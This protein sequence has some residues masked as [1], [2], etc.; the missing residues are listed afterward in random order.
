[1]KA[2]V[3]KSNNPEKDVYTAKTLE[4]CEAPWKEFDYAPKTTVGAVYDDKGLYVY[5]RTFEYPFVATYTE[6][7]SPVHNDSCL[8]MFLTANTV[9]PEYM[10]L[11]FNPNGALHIGFRRERKNKLPIECSPDIFNIKTE[12]FDDGWSVKFFVPF[13]FLEKQFA[14]GVKTEWKVNF[15]KCG[16]ENVPTMHFVSW[17]HIETEKPDFHQKQFFGTLIFKGEE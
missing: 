16:E 7:A 4:I 11:E 6:F 2:Y 17:T 15:Y 8:E 10:N 3:C 9:D 1:M 14:S 12:T 5:M 13:D